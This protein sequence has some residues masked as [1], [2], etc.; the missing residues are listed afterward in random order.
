MGQ[1]IGG[2]VVSA[3]HDF[4]KSLNYSK[5]HATASW[6]LPC[7]KSAFPTL[8]SCVEIEPD[9]WA[10]RAGIDRILILEC[11]RTIMIDEKVREKDYG[12]ILL[13]VYSD[14]E[15]KIPK[16]AVKPLACDFIAYAVAPANKCFLLPTLL[17]QKTLQ[18]NKHQWHKLAKD[19]KE[20]FSYR[21][22]INT[23]WVTVSMAIPTAVLLS[24][25]KDYMFLAWGPL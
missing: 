2:S 20:G 1:S 4:H 3:V 11:G 9:G 15:R 18:D 22:A 19:N 5:G 7:Y 14:F 6:W 13:E 24:S 25:I 17:M 8:K 12:D 10:Q 21:E 16:W 23:K